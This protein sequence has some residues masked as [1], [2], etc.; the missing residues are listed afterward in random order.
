MFLLLIVV[1]VLPTVASDDKQYTALHF[2]TSSNDYIGFTYNMAPFQDSFSICSWIKRVDTS[3][4]YPL[5]FNYY[6][7]GNEIL[8]TSNGHYNHV[9]GD[10]DLNY[11]ESVFTTPVRSWFHYCITWSLASRSINLYLDGN[12]IGTGTTDSGRTLKMGG[13]LFFN[14]FS[15]STS[16]SSIFGGQIY[17]FNIFSEALS[18]ADVKKIAEGGMCSDLTEFSGTGDLRWEHIL[19]Q[20]RSGSVR[21]VEIDDNDMV[22]CLKTRL[23]RSQEELANVTG[24]LNETESQLS[25]TEDKLNT[26]IEEL[27]AVRGK[28]NSTEEKLDVVTRDLNKTDAAME[29]VIGQLNSTQEE[30]N[31][32]QE[33]LGT[34]KGVLNVTQEELQ[35][36]S[37]QHN[38]TGEKLDTCSTSLTS[39][40]TQLETARTYKYI[41]RWDVL[42]TTPY[43][44][45]V[46]TE[47]LFQQLSSSW[48]LLG[49]FVGTNITEGIVDHFRQYH[50]EP[51]CDV[52]EQLSYPMLRQFEGVEWTKNINDHLRDTHLVNREDSPCESGT[53]S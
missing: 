45:K 36:E 13:T 43:Y 53:E 51:V 30:L 26:T 9:V 29:S 33:E 35:T 47:E 4:S 6:A 17:Q 21:E 14:R 48:G 49:K 5:V 44:N 3:N 42:Y 41:T 46:L 50:Q 12:L 37:A 1:I 31:T 32:T 20:S 7:S 24:R 22:E 8:I 16:S 11:K 52:F 18:S 34:V 15:Y 23:K 25:E 38:K 39:T 10:G 40:L 2:G 19:S 28:L 27:G